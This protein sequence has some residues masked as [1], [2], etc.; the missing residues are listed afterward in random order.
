MK[1]EKRL[2]RRR[3]AAAVEF[4]VCVSVLFLVIFAIIEF[5][6]L[7]QLQHA[8][9]QA[10]LEGARTGMTLDATTTTTQNKANQ[11]L[12]MVGVTDGTVTVSP[13]PLAYTSPS[14]SVTVSVDPAGNSWWMQFLTAGHP[15]TA[16]ITLDR[17]VQAISVP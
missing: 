4:A 5:S 13:N 10:A 11:I 3:A 17:E 2:H 12:N 1:R 7:S 16:T 9:R 8:V 14:V 15:L 6:R